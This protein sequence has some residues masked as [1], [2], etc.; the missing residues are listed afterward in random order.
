MVTDNVKVAEIDT[1]LLKHQ[2]HIKYNKKVKHHHQYSKIEIAICHA[3]RV[4][5]TPC[6]NSK[7]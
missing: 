6:P 5:Y 4:K 3:Q 1:M 7:G 2:L